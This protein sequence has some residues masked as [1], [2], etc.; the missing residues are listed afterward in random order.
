ME[1]EP[2]KLQSINE[3]IIPA[4]TKYSGIR[5]YN[6]KKPTKWGFKNFVRTGK[7]G[8]SYDFFL[9]TGAKSVGT[10]KCTAESVVLRLSEGVPKHS[11]YYLYFDN[12]FSILDLMLNLKSMGIL[13]TATFRSNG[14]GSFPL[15]TETELKKKGRGSSDYRTDQ[16]SGLHLVKWFENKCVT[17]GSMNLGVKVNDTFKK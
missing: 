3:Q 8:I 11:N 2:E 7:C 4:K 17:V 13:A 15:E 9:Y 10:G 12:W 14:I 16:N 5:R 6:A 1:I